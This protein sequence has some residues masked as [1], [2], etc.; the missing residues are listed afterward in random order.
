MGPDLFPDMTVLKLSILNTKSDKLG[1]CGNSRREDYFDHPTG[2][3]ATKKREYMQDP[4]CSRAHSGGSQPCTL[5]P[6]SQ[7]HFGSKGHR[8]NAVADPGR[9]PSGS[10]PCPDFGRVFS[11]SVV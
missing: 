6:T 10:C 5:T 4:Y 1:I 11:S 2:D 8:T 9:G 3:I 7:N